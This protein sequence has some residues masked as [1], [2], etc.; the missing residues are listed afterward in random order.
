MSIADKLATIAENEQRVYAAGKQAEHRRFWDSFQ[1][2]GAA[3]VGDVAF[4]YG[5]NDETYNPIYP[6]KIKHNVAK[7]FAYNP[8]I[9][10]TKVDIYILGSTQQIFY[11]D[12]NLKTIRKLIVNNNTTYGNMFYG[13]TALENLLIEGTIAS[14]IKLQW[15]KKLSKVSIES[16]IGHLS[17][18]T[19]GLTATF[20]T[21]AKNNAFTQAEWDALIA[22]KPNW[23]IALTEV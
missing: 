21:T 20:S 13:C 2:R 12:T 14:A 10:D 16:V 18:T 22:T 6:I 4:R 8:D 5:W 19:T 17:D 1:N 23:T 9:T 15:S 11:N 7:T 3:E